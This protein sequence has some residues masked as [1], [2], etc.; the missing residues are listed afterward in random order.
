[1]PLGGCDTPYLAEI[2]TAGQHTFGVAAIDDAGNIDPTPA[3]RTW[4]IVDMS[5]PDTSILSGPDGEVTETTAEFDV[6]GLRGAHRPA[7]ERVRVRARLGR[8]RRLHRAAVHVSPASPS[9]A[10]VLQVR[11]KDPAGNV[12]ISPDFWEW[13]VIGP[14]DTTPPDTFIV[15]GPPV[16]NSGPDVLFGFQSNEMVEEYECSSTAA[17]TVRGEAC[18]AV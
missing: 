10:H 13:V 9:G 15:L 8:L 11:A 3:E 17:S 14:P 1:M 7:R 6:R 4:T 5:P 18:E 16:D 2:E 12:D